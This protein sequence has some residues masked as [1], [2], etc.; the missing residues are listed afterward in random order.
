MYDSST[1]VSHIPH[2]IPSTVKMVHYYS[3]LV[4]INEQMLIHY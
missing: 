2:T 4:K 1:K 3:I